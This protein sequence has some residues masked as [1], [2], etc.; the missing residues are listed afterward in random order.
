[1]QGRSSAE[2]LFPFQPT[3]LRE[4]K[5]SMREQKGTIILRSDR[6]YVSYWDRR[7]V[8]GAVERKRVTHYLGEKTTRSKY[9]PADIEDAC[10]RFMNSVTANSQTVR[11]EHVLT[12]GD[13]VDSV[14]L[15][16]VR[17][18]RRASTINGYEKMWETHLKA[19]F[20]NS[21][22]LRDYQP[23]QA[24]AFLTKLAESLGLNSVKH[25]RSLMSGIF[26]HAA[27]LGYTN[28]NPIHLAKV[29]ITPKAPK[30]TA[31]Y[32][33]LEMAIALELLRINSPARTAMALAFIGLRPSEIRG[34]KRED[35]DLD[36][37]ALRVR[38]SAWR[39]SIN[40]GG[41]DKN[42]VR[43]V[44]LGPTLVDIL[45]EHVKTERSQRGFLLE[46]TLGN[47]L[48]LDALARDVIRPLFAASN[49][50]W[51]G[52]YGGRRGAETEMNRYTK[53]NSQITSHHFGHTK[54]VADA[55]YIK[56][57]PEETKIAALA[58]DA[59]LRETIGRLEAQ[60]RTGAN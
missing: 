59:T 11:P 6:W 52:Y 1:M 47:P 39:S 15:P 23:R 46:N 22:L 21:T 40:E 17:A 37:G 38:R 56:P 53:G 3:L 2:R 29:L 33:V 14:Y 42:S 27:A 8:N 44:T 49:L 9:P 45:R 31:H 4:R 26:K 7:N 34:L 16:W 18:N 54:A 55:H 43:E 10:K 60:A 20:G 35:I 25:V 12:I 32:T 24:T 48:D 30:E 51:K 50:S 58:L 57:I 41:K 36:M 28:T 19:H 5:I 13:F